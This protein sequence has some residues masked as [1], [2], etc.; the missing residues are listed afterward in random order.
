MRRLAAGSLTTMAM[1]TA[2]GVLLAHAGRPPEPHDLWIEWRPPAVL[3]AVVTVVCVAYARGLR[4]L[5]RQAGPSRGITRAEA[6][7]F[8]AAIASLLVAVGSPLDM[9]ASALF[10]AHMVQHL[11]LVLVTGPLLAFARPERALLWAMD[12]PAR[13]TLAGWWLQRR[14]LRSAWAT[15]S[16]P[17]VAWALHAVIIW[18]WHTPKLYDAAAANEAVH[19]LEHVTFVASAVLFA[20]PLVRVRGRSTGVLSTGGA[21]LYLFAAAMQSGILGALLT[22]SGSVW[23]GAHLTT[24]GPWGMTPLEDQHVAGVLM[25]GPAGGAYL[26][27]ILWAMRGWL[28]DSPVPARVARQSTPSP[29][30]H[31]VPPIVR[32]DVT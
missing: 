23:Y 19:V 18:A 28:D 4:T 26:L 1:L 10:S 30:V 15:V 20:R 3:L 8:A 14:T 27:G 17:G 9:M 31:R 24:T 13:R 29:G 16:S 12:R 6:W 2:P 32:G 7:C 21:V 11:V 5:W 22:L 25:W